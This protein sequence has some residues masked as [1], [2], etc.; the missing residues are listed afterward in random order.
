MIP[1]ATSLAGILSIVVI[2]SGLVKGPAT[3]PAH[4]IYSFNYL[5][6]RAWNNGS[7]SNCLAFI[8]FK[9]FLVAK[10]LDSAGAATTYPKPWYSILPTLVNH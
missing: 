4:T 6:N 2:P 9:A 8:P 3:K 5:L 1:T 10:T 7:T